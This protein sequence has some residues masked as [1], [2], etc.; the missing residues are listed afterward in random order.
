MGAAAPA[1]VAGAAVGVGAISGVISKHIDT[2]KKKC[3][4]VL[5]LGW[6]CKTEWSLAAGL[7]KPLAFLKFLS[8]H[9]EM[10]SIRSRFHFSPSDG[11]IPGLNEWHTFHR[12]GGREQGQ[13]TDFDV[14]LMGEEKKGGNLIAIEVIFYEPWKLRD[15]PSIRQ[16]VERFLGTLSARFFT[17]PDRLNFYARQRRQMALQWVRRSYEF[18]DRYV[19]RCCQ[20]TER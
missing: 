16:D 3:L 12:P 2:L 1:V 9:Q 18:D 4:E 7:D 8:R 17:P 6:Q 14:F 5:H 19:W 11:Y 13:P 10:H 15:A 20:G